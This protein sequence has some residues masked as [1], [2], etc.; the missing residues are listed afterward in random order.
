MFMN[1]KDLYHSIV[2]QNSTILSNSFETQTTT[3]AFDD[4]YNTYGLLVS[5]IDK[6]KGEDMDSKLSDL[7]DKECEN[8]FTV[9]FRTAVQLLM[10]GD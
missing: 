6:E 4:F 9:G 3:D 2:Q 7:I 8:A 5:K 10:N 1:V